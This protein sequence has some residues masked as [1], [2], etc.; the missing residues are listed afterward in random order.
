MGSN[1]VSAVVT[2]LRSMRA[3]WHYGGLHG[4]S[5]LASAIRR[6]QRALDLVSPDQVDVE[7]PWCRGLIPFALVGYC[8]AAHKLGHSAEA[9]AALAR[10]RPV[11]RRW[12]TRPLT[13]E[14]R[15][16]YAWLEA[17]P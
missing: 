9:A 13:Q 8:D 12:L 2:L 16:A 14:E 1:A 11:Y 4:P 3:S 10:W 6:Y 17:Q 5:I 7:A 15:T